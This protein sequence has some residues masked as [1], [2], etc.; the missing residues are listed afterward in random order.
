MTSD[1]LPVRCIEIGGP[2]VHQQQ[3][4]L[5]PDAASGTSGIRPENRGRIRAAGSKAAPMTHGDHRRYTRRAMNAL[6]DAAASGFSLGVLIIGSLLWDP[7]RD[8]WRSRLRDVD[9]P[10]RVRVPIRYGRFSE[11]RQSYT[12]VLS[13]DL[14]E[15]RFGHAVAIQC[16]SQDIVEEAKCL[17]A[18]ER[19]KDGDCGVSASW[20][21]VGL[22]L[23]TDS[24]TLPAEQP[25]RWRDFVNECGER[26]SNYEA[27]ATAGA[28]VDQEGILTIDWPKLDAGPNSA[29]RCVA[30]DGHETE[31]ARFRPPFAAGHRGRVEDDERQAGSLVLLEQPEAPH[32]DLPGRRHRQASAR[33]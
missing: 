4:P 15:S 32:I 13:P 7:E 10:H 18:A 2:I 25:S 16:K 21:C 17:W 28:G 6:Q 9:E 1:H 29:V 33:F 22:L 3:P 20:G 14:D 31:S 26:R 23:N 27:L 5:E 11:R 30:R 8:A 24:K 12:M 19:K